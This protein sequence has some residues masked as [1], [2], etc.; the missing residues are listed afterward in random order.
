MSSNF[1]NAA[2]Y[3]A[4]P[5]VD[6]SAWDTSQPRGGSLEGTLGQQAAQTWGMGAPVPGSTGIE[7]VLAQQGTLDTAPPPSPV[8]ALGQFQAA[9]QAQQ[10]DQQPFFNNL[11]FNQKTGTVKVEMPQGA[12]ADVMAQLTDL[13]TM[14][15]AAMARVAQLQQQEASGSPLIDA[16]SQISGHLAANDPTMPGW[17]RA[18]GAANLQMGPQGIR[19]R[20]EEEEAKV[21]N[22]SK[23]I[24]DIGMDAEKLQI[25]QAQRDL[26]G[27]ERVQTNWEQL[28]SSVNTAAQKGILPDKNYFFREGFALGKDLDALEGEWKNAETLATN[29]NKQK[30][31]E[32]QRA[33]DKAVATEKGKAPIRIE[34]GE[35]L[36]DARKEDAKELI[37]LRAGIANELA[38]KRYRSY[39]DR[40]LTRMDANRVQ[41]LARVPAKVR[42]NLIATSEM[43]QFLER[44]EKYVGPNGSLRSKVGP[45]Q[46]YITGK[47]PSA[48]SDSDRQVVQHLFGVEKKRVIDFARA[49]VRGWAPGEDAIRKVGML[50]TL[51]PDA[52]GR[53]IEE[54]RHQININRKAATDAY[55]YAPWDQTPELLGGPGSPI[56]KDAAA[57]SREFFGALEGV[58][59]RSLAREAGGDATATAPSTGALPQSLV[60]ALA[61]VPAGKGIRYNGKTY[62]MQGG[63]PVEVR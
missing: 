39:Q 50:E 55:R 33:I 42:E 11:S 13:K 35:K 57:K 16:L 40:V 37:T 46:G 5:S 59:Q 56:Y 43:E 4:I 47:L 15:T 2:P 14:K 44:L 25:A 18:L 52:A 45:L 26:A 34:V 62:K 36:S 41:E 21:A 38:D 54:I 30:E 7:D 58:H 27:N 20:R 3:F 49:G 24:A 12:L 28:R 32:D 31:I 53:V 51:T 22:L 61:K 1:I 48:L 17:V 29:Y 6:E 9:R 19:R 8:A 10:T 60:D 63:V 23:G